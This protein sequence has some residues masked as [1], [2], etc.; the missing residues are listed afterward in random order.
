MKKF[1]LHII[2]IVGFVILT[3]IVS[4]RKVEANYSNLQV[5]AYLQDGQP[6]PSTINGLA[7]F[8]DGNGSSRHLELSK[9]ENPTGSI[10][11][12]STVASNCSWFYSW[13]EYSDKQREWLSSQSFTITGL[14][15]FQRSTTSG[16]GF[17]CAE[18][19][20]RASF[21]LAGYRCDDVTLQHQDNVGG[22]YSQNV[23]CYPINNAP[24]ITA[25]FPS[26]CPRDFTYT[27]KATDLQGGNT[28]K[29]VSLRIEDYRF[30][31][32]LTNVFVTSII[33]NTAAVIS[34]TTPTAGL[35]ASVVACDGSGNTACINGN[36]AIVK[37]MVTGFPNMPAFVVTSV[38]AKDTGN[39]EGPWKI[40]GN[41]NFLDK[42]CLP[43]VSITNPHNCVDEDIFTITAGDVQGY[44]TIKRMYLYFFFF[45]SDGSYGTLRYATYNISG[46]STSGFSAT[47]D[48]DPL[49]PTYETGSFLTYL[50]PTIQ[51]GS[52]GRSVCVVNNN[53]ELKV[54]VQGFNS[55]YQD[56]NWD[57]MKGIAELHVGAM[58]LSGNRVLTLWDPSI[59]KIGYAYD[60]TNLQ[61]KY[62]TIGTQP[63]AAIKQP[64]DHWEGT[65]AYMA[66][67][68]TNNRPLATSCSISCTPKGGGTCS[69]NP[70][71]ACP[72][73]V[74]ATN[75]P[76]LSC[77][78]GA[79]DSYDIILSFQNICGTATQTLPNTESP[80]P[81]FLTSYGDTYSSG[82]YSLKMEK[83]KDFLNSILPSGEPAYFSTYIIAKG[84]SANTWINR[85]SFGNSNIPYLLYNYQDVNRGSGPTIDV[86][87]VLKEIAE[88]NSCSYETTLPASCPSGSHVYFVSGGGI[89]TLADNWAS[90]DPDS[91]RACVIISD[92]KLIVPASGNKVDAFLF[93][94][95]G[96]ETAIGNGTLVI[97]GG[98]ISDTIKFQ[99]AMIDNSLNPSEVL[100]YD[101]K[102]LDL[103]RD[104]LGE[105]YPFNVRELQYSVTQ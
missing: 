104:C 11:W 98:V 97:N 99:R 42:S 37:V 67:N 48:S 78:L 43:T 93:A 4:T 9:K 26:L 77:T 92:G 53:L 49:D 94:N 85:P 24:D 69:C 60:P 59:T 79:G 20:L 84:D 19:P 72:I 89:T 81:W 68:V 40:L 73:K 55:M 1:I 61:R 71:G 65:T 74:D 83:K 30:N 17:G 5:C 90:Q 62:F 102:Y 14:G 101:A 2:I 75:P 8:H 91:S 3:S 6:L 54:R 25:D 64:F 41:T 32:I 58:E 35:Q 86:Y 12:F 15:S 27:M 56:S 96:V 7:V 87:S 31:G 29:E 16:G 36:E 88:R 82:S 38:K 76:L 51:D 39:A 44:D 23:T 80:K 50:T 103:L 47:L 100:Q 105:G 66:W 45:K 21:I 95:K 18:A 34:S 46:D 52:C 13:Q 10:V 33:G 57:F 22:T 70:F 28:V 63:I